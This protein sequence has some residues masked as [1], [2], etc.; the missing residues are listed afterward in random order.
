M[1]EINLPR[2]LDCSMRHVWEIIA[3][4]TGLVIA[5]YVVYMRYLHPLAKYPGPFLA[6]LTNI[7]KANAMYGGQME[8]TIRHLHDR[9]GSIVRIGPNDLVI[10]HPDAVKQIYLSGSAFQ[11]VS[12]Q[13]SYPLMQT[14]FYN[15]FT[16]FRPN[17]FGTQ[18]E[19]IH[20]IRRRQIAHGFSQAS[21]L[22]MEP[23]IDGCLSQL[24]DALDEFARN[25]EIFDLKFWIRLYIFDCLGELAF[26]QSFGALKS[27]SE[28]LL[29]PIAKH[30][31]LSTVA[32][33][34][35]EYTTQLIKLLSY[36][37]VPWIQHLYKGRAALR[38]VSLPN[39]RYKSDGSS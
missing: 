6:S 12:P 9:Y 4:G 39:L 15:G 25:G 30:V 38:D 8:Y 16:S 32:G 13:N 2:A 35:P 5:V 33:Q 19:A 7:W 34:I 26:S 11:K 22:Q 28:E 29:P 18:D 1:D 37:P 10:S 21:I 24:I 3:L 20:S 23:Y 14:K 27:G 36:L 17:V 31:Q